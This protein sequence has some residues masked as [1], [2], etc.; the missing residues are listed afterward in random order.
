MAA[1]IEFTLLRIFMNRRIGKTGVRP[2]Y[3]FKLW[4]IA[5]GAAAAAFTVKYW[6]PGFPIRISSILVLATFGAA[7]FAGTVAFKVSETS[8]LLSTLTTRFSKRPDRN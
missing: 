1:W 5:I 8:Q 3:I 7:Y 2:A 4:A 6:T